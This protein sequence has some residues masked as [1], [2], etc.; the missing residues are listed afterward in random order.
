MVPGQAYSVLIEEGGGVVVRA[1][2]E[3]PPTDTPSRDRYIV[4]SV[5][6]A[7]VILKQ[8]G[9]HTFPIGPEHEAYNNPAPIK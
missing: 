1:Y 8:N 5:D 9:I 7:V 6:K 2:N 3:Y 4:D